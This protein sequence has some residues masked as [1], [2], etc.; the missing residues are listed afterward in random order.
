MPNVDACQELADQIRSL[1]REGIE[2]SR[3]VV[4]FI[5]ST[6]AS[7]TAEELLT[8][9]N[10]ESDSDRDTLLE[11]IFSPDEHLQE[12]IEPLLTR[13]VFSL[14]SETTVLDLLKN[15]VP[16]AALIFPD[17]RGRVA[18]IPPAWIIE[19]MVSQLHISRQ[20]PAALS[21]TIVESLRQ[22]LRNRVRV[23][24]RNL[25]ADL[26][27][28]QI[29][30]LCRYLSAAD[31]QQASFFSNLNFLAQFLDGLNGGLDIY[32][33]LMQH[34]RTCRFHLQ[35]ALK[36]EKALAES[37]L[38]TLLM[39]G[40]RILHF[41]K[42]GLMRDIAAIDAISLAVFGKTEALLSKESTIQLGEYR[43]R[44]DLNRLIKFLSES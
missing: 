42:D 31:S 6:Y 12:K 39:R 27:D 4:E 26:T 32:E 8:I 2:L 21:T 5:D 1:L 23:R 29:D 7:P 14:Q 25:K 41:D 17:A 3:E 15:Q 10:S 34:K 19:S 44:E 18:V 37:N 22:P 33:A 40:E 9:L 20:F 28:P 36:Q 38:E 30:C 43:D 11:L 13:H 16:E 24:F 35:Q